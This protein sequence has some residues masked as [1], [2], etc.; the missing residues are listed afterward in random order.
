MWLITRRSDILPP[1]GDDITAAE[2]AIDCQIEHG[3][4]AN[5][6]FDLELCPDR[7][8]VFG[9]QRGLCPGQ[10]SLVPRYSL[11]LKVGI[12]F[13]LHGHTPRLGYR[14]R[15]ACAAGSGG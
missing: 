6:A 13:I 15:E 2:L 9:S 14:G 7:P 5:A 11:G 1:E 12:Q 3:E 4:V 8:N 10:L